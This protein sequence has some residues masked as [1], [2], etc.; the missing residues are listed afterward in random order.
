[1]SETN[2]GGDGG[3]DPS[4]PSADDDAQQPPPPGPNQQATTV[5][6]PPDETDESGEAPP[7]W[8]PSEPQF[9]RTDTPTANGK[10]IALVV[11]AGFLGNL[12]LRTGSLASIALLLAVV[13]IAVAIVRQYRRVH[14]GLVFIGLAAL[15]APWLVLRVDQSLTAVNV[16]SIIGLLAVGAGLSLH[17]SAFNS[18]VRALSAHVGGLAMEWIFGLSMVQ[19]FG[20]SLSSRHQLAPILRGAALAVPVLIVFTTLLASADDVFAKFLL[21]GD[22]PSLLSHLI[23]TGLITVGLLGFLSRAAHETP[24]DDAPVN[25]RMLGPLEVLMVLGSLVLLFAGF[26]ATQIVVAAGG[27]SHILETEGL[28]RAD[29]ARQGFFQLLWVAGLAVALVGGLR[30]FRTIDPERGRDRFTPL[31]LMTLLL[32]VIIAGIS[33]QRLALYVEA[34]GLTPLRFW[35]FAGAGLITVLIVLYGLSISG[36]RGETSWY[37]GVAIVLVSLVVFGLNVANPDQR[38]A[39]YNLRTQGPAEIDA[40]ALTQLSDDAIPTLIDKVAT[41]SLDDQRVVRGQLC[42]RPNRATSYGFL[43]YNRSAIAADRA[44]DEWCGDERTVRSD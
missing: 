8:Q 37:P 26:V 5:I 36:W 28:T 35:A 7:Q 14:A 22:I 40:F 27:A 32:T 38:V 25:L 41:L 20:K 16:L 4:L 44:L 15:I 21:I 31:A 17:G 12:V 11:A 19:R 24:P 30:A 13:A 23:L 33:L 39:D 2:D 6:D 1:M 29:H 18:R 3:I 42:A 9:I 43:E 34:F 10:D